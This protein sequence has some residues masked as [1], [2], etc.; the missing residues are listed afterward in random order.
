MGIKRLGT[1]LYRMSVRARTQINRLWRTSIQMRVVTSTIVMSFIVMVV[2]GFVLMN[3]IISRLLDS[4]VF[5]AVEKIE[6]V[7]TEVE[8]D[9]NLTASKTLDYRLHH[10]LEKVVSN[11]HNSLSHD[12]FRN[13]QIVLM[14]SHAKHYA[15][16]THYIPKNLREDI[17]RSH[18]IT[19]QY[20]TS[21][22]GY[23]AGGPVLAVGSPVNSDLRNIMVFIVIPLHDTVDTVRIVQATL[24]TGS[25]LLIILISVIIFLVSR[26]VVLPVRTAARTAERFATG[27]LDQRMELHGED[28]FAKLS[29]SFNGMA[30]KLSE[31]I[32]NLEEYNNLQKRFTSDVSHELRSPLTT[33]RMAVDVLED[34]MDELDNPVTQK[35][36]E[37]LITEVN[38]FESLLT[39]LLEISRHDAGVEKLDI[40]NV[41]IAQPIERAIATLE[42][43]AHT[44]GTFFVMH[45]P[46]TAIF[47]QVE[48]RRIERIIR[49]LLA[50]AIDYCEG[51]PIDIFYAANSTTVAIVV[52]DHGV[53]LEPGQEKFIFNRF[54]RADSSRTRRTGG[55]GLGLAISYEDALLHRGKLQARGTRGKGTVF[56]LVVPL[57]P[58]ITMQP[59]GLLP[60]T[61]FIAEEMGTNNEQEDNSL[62]PHNM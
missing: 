14:D 3:Q 26:Q 24:L 23:A 1:L 45:P 60:I 17:E 21:D 8:R 16:N 43:L 41:D 44:A 10:A 13:E 18:F 2:L 29:H 40:E 42:D 20:F 46:Q 49:N 36:T 5:T 19:Y 38:R 39:D 34:H 58:G 32:E 54:W 4:K 9:L 7:R 52:W 15:G 28:D 57:A 30:E 27:H 35:S 51:N 12:V 25:L 55:T 50:N 6:Y 56:R 33:I 22:D 48:P 47:V 53:G 59:D 31:Q 61:S 11:T 62:P 37:L